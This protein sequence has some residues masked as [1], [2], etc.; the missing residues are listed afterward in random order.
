MADRTIEIVV[1]VRDNTNGKVKGL[2]NQLKELDRTAQRLANRFKSF[3]TMKYRAMIELIDRVTEPGNRINNLLRRLAGAAWRVS[4]HLTDGALGK[5]RQVESLLMRI[6]SRAYN[7]AVNV[8]DNLRGKFGGLLNG[9]AMGAGMLM[10]LGGAMGV[11]FGVA[12]GIQAY[13]GFEQQMSRVQAIRQLSKDSTEMKALTQLAKDLGMQTA[14]TRQ[15]VGQAME[16]QALAGWNTN[17][18]LQSTPHLLNL[19]SAGGLDLGRTSDIVTDA[20]TAFGLKAEETYTNKQGRQVNAVEHF[21]DMLAKMQ[22]ISNT[23]ISQAGEAF[24]YGASTI[25]AMYSGKDIQTRMQATEDAMIMTGLMANAGIKGSM[26]G[27]GINTIFNRMGSMNRNAYNALRAMGVEYKDERGDMLS[28]GTIMRNLS[29]RFKEGI[30]PNQLLTFAEEISGEKIHA[31][32][33]RKLDSLIEQTAKNGGKMGSSDMLKMAGMLAGTEHMGKLLAVMLGDWDAMAEKMDNVN[34]TAKEMAETMLDNLAGSFTK[35]GSAWDAFQQGF[36]EGSAGE[37]LRGFVDSLTEL[38]TRANKLFSDGIQI[39][40]FGKIIGDIIGRLKNKFLELDGVGSILAG[41]ALAAGLMKIVS[42]SQRAL[43]AIRN[44]GRASVIGGAT[45]TTGVSAAQKVGTMHVSAGSVHVNGKVSGGGGGTAVGY[46]G[47]KN[48]RQRL[49]NDWW[50]TPER[51][52]ARANTRAVMADYQSVKDY[53]RGE[54]ASVVAATK[55]FNAERMAAM[56]SAAAGGAAFAG[57]FGLMDIMNLKAMNAERLAGAAPEERAQIIRENRQAEFEAGAGLTG[58]V[59]G[60]ALGSALGSFAGPIGTAIGGIVG[61]MIGQVIGVEVGKTGAENERNNS[62]NHSSNVDEKQIY[63]KLAGNDGVKSHGFEDYLDLTERQGRVNNSW[64]LNPQTGQNYFGINGEDITHPMN[65]PANWRAMGELRR[66]AGHKG[67]SL[68]RRMEQLDQELAEEKAAMLARQ[69]ERWQK[70]NGQWQDNASDFDYYRQQRETRHHGGGGL[71]GNDWGFS[72]AEAGTPTAEQLATEGQVSMPEI[73]PPETSAFDEWIA[74]LGTQ[75]TD[76]LA[77]IS[78]GAGEIFA[79][80]SDSISAGLEAASSMATSALES[81]QSAFAS[82]KDTIQSAWS[83]LPGFF[84]GIFSGLG[85]AAQAAGSAIYSGL[86]SVIGSVIGAWESA[87]S[88]IG[89]IISQIGSMASSAGAGVS[90]AVSSV[91]A[92]VRGHAE[93]GFVT[94]PELSWLGER[95]AELV[96]PLTDR[97]RSLEL[98]NQASGMLGLDSGLPSDSVVSQGTA[99]TESLD[100]GGVTINASFTMRANYPSVTSNVLAREFGR[101]TELTIAPAFNSKIE[102]RL[103]RGF[104][105]RELVTPTATTAIT[106]QQGK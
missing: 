22:A 78:A 18:I 86:T 92:R 23:D 60:A 41:G 1:D 98:L 56:R 83:E 49:I 29:R 82:A 88:T 15:Q 35:L 43:N 67:W 42:L 10:P 14:W 84:E 25:G 80:L 65:S 94:S 38:V 37:G 39:G 106:N 32:T 50:G 17:Q 66:G 70:M 46:G 52:R 75:L 28:V 20:M 90:G 27:T 13:A 21:A 76:G 2:A 79:G 5:L 40:D 99:A 34:G 91:I 85:G 101:P 57:I 71:F 100:V 26:A 103:K 87:S 36:M 48:S 89:G 81:I 64:L 7:I 74:N 53:I 96:L 3:A 44:V 77:N 73:V 30:D 51:N 47:G 93:G 16:Y 105:L 97:E 24:K 8:K 95:G 59:I 11:G 4:L 55:Y 62:P 54:Q 72:H 6:T 104:D 12:N 45:S 63:D 19:A 61:G 68:E 31:D 69:K 33:R 9:A 102:P 58:S